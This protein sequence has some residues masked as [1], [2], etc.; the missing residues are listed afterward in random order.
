MCQKKIRGCHSRKKSS[1]RTGEADFGGRHRGK[2]KHVFHFGFTCQ[3]WALIKAEAFI[4]GYISPLFPLFFR[5]P[6]LF[7][8][9][10]SA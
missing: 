1:R 10:G 3:H 5:G 8:E 9:G 2:F 7:L 6:V 4:S